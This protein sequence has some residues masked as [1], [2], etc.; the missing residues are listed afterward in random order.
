MITVDD[1][2]NDYLTPVDVSQ[3]Q[4]RRGRQASL[5]YVRLVEA[6]VASGEA[7]VRINVEKMGRKPATVRSALAKALKTTA[8]RETIRVSLIGDDVFLVRR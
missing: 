6:F 7:A 2:I 3:L 5:M 8:N 4:V 1:S